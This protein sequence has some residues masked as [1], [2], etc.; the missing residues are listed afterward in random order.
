LAGGTGEFFSLTLP[1]FASV[2]S[3][4]VRQANGR[5]PVVAGCGY[6]TAIAKQFAQAADGAGADGLL[7][8]PPYLGSV[9][10]GVP[11]MTFHYFTRD[12]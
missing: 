5:L 1:E 9:P 8:L 4:G 2:A 10:E 7:L 11:W 3:A 6:G 12:L